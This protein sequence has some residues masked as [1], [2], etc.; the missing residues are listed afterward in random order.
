MKFEELVPKQRYIVYENIRKEIENKI[1][2]PFEQ[3]L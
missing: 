3:K 1:Y 2:E